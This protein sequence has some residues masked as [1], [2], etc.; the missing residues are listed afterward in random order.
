MASEPPPA[1]EFAPHGGDR[2][3]V[4]KQ[5]L[6]ACFS[7]LGVIRGAPVLVHSS[8]SSL[9][10]VRDGADTVI[11]ALLEVIGPD[12]LLI[13]PTHTWSTVGAK[14][15]VFHETLSPSTT[16]AITEQLRKRPG[17]IRSLHPTHSVAALGRGA[18]Q[19]C[20]G[21][22]LLSTPCARSSPYGRLVSAGG[23]VL[24]V[25]VGLESF[26]VMHAFEEWAEVPW[27]F[28]RTEELFVL[29][30]AGET[31]TV[32]SQR[33]TDDPHYEERDFPSLEPVLREGAAIKYGCV[34][35]AG[36]RLVDAAAAC[37]LL[38][39]LI[40]TNPDIVL[41]PSAAGES[42]PGAD[43]RPGHRLA[44]ACSN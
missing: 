12:G 16:G 5:E 30:A 31:L 19:F 39:P 3:L 29:T 43:Q 8:L 10:L 38:L 21:H 2:P 27:L 34:G 25:G 33:H 6:A 44:P 22:E 1:T 17:A 13:M 23:Q 26:T 32:T 37:E 20:R 36:V 14:Q 24:L 40:R 11:D 4:T 41:G 28:N 35:N 18:E 9:G 42:Y 7:Q 15:P